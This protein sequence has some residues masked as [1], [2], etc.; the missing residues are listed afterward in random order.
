MLAA[1][2]DAAAAV[3]DA[4]IGVVGRKAGEGRGLAG[5]GGSELGEVGAQAGG[6]ERAA[7]RDG[8]EDLAASAQGGVGAYS[9]GKRSGFRSEKNRRNEMKKISVPI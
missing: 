7:A 9:E 5:A 1:A 3:V 4:G 8:A 2:A 6:I